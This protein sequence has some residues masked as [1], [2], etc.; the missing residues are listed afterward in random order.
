MTTPSNK[1]VVGISGASGSIYAKKLIEKLDEYK[2]QNRIEDVALVFS[3]KASEVWKHEIG[4]HNPATLPFKTY[5]NFDFHAPFA[6]GSSDFDSMVIC[7][8]SVGMMGR[9]ANGSG[10][11]LICRAA[12]VMLKEKR[13]L[14]LVVRETPFN[15][16]H[17]KNMEALCVAGAQILPANPSFYSLPQTID[18]VVMTVVNRILSNLH[19]PDNN[20]YHWGK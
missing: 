8:C 19:I 3:D 16:I 13:K 12:D 7:P 1:I 4:D 15:L 11:D 5:G 18:D 9:I 20:S 14:I 6:S 10:T 2:I 17:I